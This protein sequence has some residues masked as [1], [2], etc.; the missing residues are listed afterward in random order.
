MGPKGNKLPYVFTNP[1]SDTELFSCDRVFVL[2][3]TPLPIVS[4]SPSL[5]QC[6]SDL[7]GQVEAMALFEARSRPSTGAKPKQ[8]IPQERQREEA[9]ILELLQSLKAQQDVLASTVQELQH[10]MTKPRYRPA[11]S[12][13]DGGN[14]NGQLH[15]PLLTSPHTSPRLLD[16]PSSPKT[17]NHPRSTLSQLG[18]GGY[19]M[20]PPMSPHNI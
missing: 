5:T 13:S 8:S 11:D 12:L 15:S 10:L 14:S 1:P 2:S 6:P 16:S 20:A 7:T 3:Q 9:S 17:L 18:T 4:T 19:R